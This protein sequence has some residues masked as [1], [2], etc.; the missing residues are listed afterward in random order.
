MRASPSLANAMGVTSIPLK[1]LKKQ[2]TTK[3][4]KWVKVNGLDIHYQDVGEGPVVVLVHGIMSSLQTWDGWI[5]ELE[6]DHRVISLDVPGYGL[7][8]APE[9]AD[10]FNEA[11]LINTFAKF[12]D[13]IELERFSLA[14]NSLGGYISAQYASLYPDRVERLI[15]LD[16]VAYPQPVPW[17]FE[18]AIAP[19]V[20]Q[21]GQLIQPPLFVTMTMNDVYGDPSR[22]TRYH[23]D[24]Y[25]HMSQR[26][27]AKAA[28]IKTI[29]M[30]VERST[31]EMPMPF[32]RIKAPTLL[33]WGE[34]DRWVPVA[35]TKRWQEDIRDSQVLIYPGV[36]HMPMEE[37]PEKSVA[38]AKAFLSGEPLP[39]AGLAQATVS[40][41]DSTL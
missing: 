23:Q 37:I 33:M 32:H 1:D 18:L 6:K 8:G 11:F 21:M 9:N 25:V 31:T 35:L 2:Y 34:S 30:L 4:S 7:T 12:I 13:E 26:P 39:N 5:P 29:E 15:L 22:L 16:P 28:Y 38:D 27:G 3:D 20:A 19:G 41:A 10:D 24:R 14:G 40:H 17:I 36:G